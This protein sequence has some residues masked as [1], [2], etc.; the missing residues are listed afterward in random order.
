MDATVACSRRALPGNQGRDKDICGTS[1]P[2]DTARMIANH[3]WWR[4]LEREDNLVSWTSSTLF[5]IRCM[6]YRQYNHNDG[7]PLEDISL[8]V[9]DTKKFLYDMFIRDL[10]LIAA[11]KCFDNNDNNSLEAID[12]LRDKPEFYSGE[13]PS[14][15]SLTVRGKCS[16]ISAQTM[17][18][19]GLLNL[20]NS[21]LQAWH[22]VDKENWVR[23][24]Q[25][26]RASI[27]SALKME[28][29]PPELIGQGS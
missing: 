4:K 15:G 16:H 12:R 23:S 24:V 14:Q 21:F 20:H 5:A 22:G 3:L 9:L 13:S 25:D 26:V 28:Q 2:A 1:A 17:V 6:S 7:S 19:A 18:S 29:A 11:F 8:L 10:D 27:G